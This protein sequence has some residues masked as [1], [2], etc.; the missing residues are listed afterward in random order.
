MT[1]PKRVVIGAKE[2]L[3]YKASGF[4]SGGKAE[5]V[6]IDQPECVPQSQETATQRCLWTI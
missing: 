2:F 5:G 3:K 4:L 1:L 6:R